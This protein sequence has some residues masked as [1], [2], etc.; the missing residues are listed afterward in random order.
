MLTLHGKIPIAFDMHKNEVTALRRPPTFYVM[1]SR[2]SYLPLI[3]RPARETFELAAPD[4][5]AGGVWFEHDGQALRWHVPLG[6]LYDLHGVR[7]LP[8]KITVRFQGFP[9]K[10]NLIPLGN[11]LD[12]EKTFFHSLKQAASLRFGSARRVMD[13][14]VH[15]QES[16]WEGIVLSDLDTVARIRDALTM[17]SPGDAATQQVPLRVL[18]VDRDEPPVL[19]TA[20]VY[21]WSVPWSESLTLKEAVRITL[22]ASDKSIEDGQKFEFIVQGV[23]PPGDA[24]V[25]EVCQEMCAHDLF[26][27]VVVEINPKT[28]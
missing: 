25:V 23:R 26:L 3:S 17:P 16:F 4:V 28:N 7:E 19:T 24:P 22:D 15:G 11:E 8:F 2:L 27:Y 18:V 10:A 1:G 13:L 14:P 6:V 21:Q 12:V 20:R 5:G 9:T